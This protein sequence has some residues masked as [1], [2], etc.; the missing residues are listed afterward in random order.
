MHHGMRHPSFV[1]RLSWCKSNAL[2]VRSFYDAS[3]SEM[4]KRAHEESTS[5]G[6]MNNPI[7]N[8][9]LTIAMFALFIFSLTGQI[10]TGFQEYN[11]NQQDHQQAE[12]GL[13]EYLGTGHLIEAV[14]ENWESEFL[15]MASYVILTVFLFQ[16]G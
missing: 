3:G 10:F 12:V 5:G 6:A 14:F 2:P 13:V 11:E 16:K 7:R 1:G 8:T 15:Q 9:G 4:M